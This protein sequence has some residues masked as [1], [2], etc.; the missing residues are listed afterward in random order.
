MFD[1]NSSGESEYD[2]G[3]V[4]EAWSEFQWR[5]RMIMNNAVCKGTNEQ[6]SSVYKD[7]NEQKSSVYKDQN[8]S[9]ER[10]YVCGNVKEVWS[11][12]QWTKRMIMNNDVCKGTNEQKCS[13]CKGKNEQKS[14]VYKNTNARNI[15]VYKDTTVLNIAV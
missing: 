8:S 12:F 6:K 14:S 13:V 4:K 15:S 2:C 3:N 1:Q 11:E 9:G 7:T 10:E 5:K